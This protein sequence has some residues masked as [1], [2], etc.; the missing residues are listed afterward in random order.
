MGEMGHIVFVSMGDMSQQNFDFCHNFLQIHFFLNLEQSNRFLTQ[1]FKIFFYFPHMKYGKVLVSP[2][3]NQKFFFAFFH[4]LG[5]IIPKK[6]CLERKKHFRLSRGVA[7][8]DKNLWSLFIS[9][10]KR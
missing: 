3:E 5:V 7:A 9:R 10:I 6:S 1:I 8:V 4:V 2:P